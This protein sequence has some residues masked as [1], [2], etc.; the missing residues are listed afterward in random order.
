V[1][2]GYDL[3]ISGIRNNLSV[4]TDFAEYDIRINPNDEIEL[5]LPKADAAGNLLLREKLPTPVGTS[6]PPA[7]AISLTRLRDRDGGC[8]GLRF[9]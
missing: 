1:A 6:S 9:E 7:T 2:R 5:F 4:I 3:S 8:R